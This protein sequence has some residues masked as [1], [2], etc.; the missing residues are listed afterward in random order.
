MKLGRRQW[1]LGA[2]GAGALLSLRGNVRATEPTSRKRLVLVMTPNGTQPGN[3]WPREGTFLSPIL[4]PLLGDPQ[5]SAKTT[6][7]KG[8]FVPR[9]ANGTE[10]NEHDMGFARMFTGAQLL[11]VAGKPWGGAASLDQ[12]LGRAWG[13]SPMNLAV[14]TSNIEPVP[15]VGLLHRRSFSYVAPGVLALPTLDPREAFDRLFVPSVP[16][17]PEE[18]ARLAR[19]RTVIGSNLADLRALRNRVGSAEHDRIALHESSL[20]ELDARLRAQADGTRIDFSSCKAKPLEPASF[21]GEARR[22]LV[23]D[24][25]R[26]P[27]LTQNMTSLIAAAIGCGATRVATLQLGYA[28]ARGAFPWLFRKQESHELA[29]R[30]T[31]LPSV[32]TQ[33][34][35]ELTTIHTWYASQVAELARK[36]DAIPEAD[37][38]TALDHTLIVW[39][40]EFGRGDHLQSDVPLVLVGG[41]S[42][43]VRGGRLVSMGP[44]TFQRLGCTILRAM[45]D[46]PEAASLVRGFGDTPDCGPLSGVFA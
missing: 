42:G 35:S 10:A 15:R 45:A 4:A 29:H 30:D 16:A 14:V 33:V 18:Q 44:Q 37:G 3:F 5:L 13:T 40:S 34:T 12:V 43:A 21:S 38:T 9:E 27:E 6:V 19:R 28:G 25:S 20:T 8:M 23:D 2:A 17:T 1:L 32:P 31:G 46:S 7:V 39:T 22:F 24:E 11:S 26:V 41:A 36:L